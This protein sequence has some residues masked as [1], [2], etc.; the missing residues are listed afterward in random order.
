LFIFYFQIRIKAKKEDNSAE[1]GKKLLEAR[2]KLEAEQGKKLLEARKNL[3]AEQGK[4]LL[5]ARKKLENIFVIAFVIYL[6]TTCIRGIL[7]IKR[8]YFVRLPDTCC[9]IG[10]PKVIH[11]IVRFH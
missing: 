2:K 6:P 8:C 9:H 1:Q 10:I 3:E 7:S 5:Q 4:K 11:S